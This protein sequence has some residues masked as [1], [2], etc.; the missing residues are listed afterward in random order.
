[1]GTPDDYISQTLKRIRYS[2]QKVC[3]ATA[4]IRLRHREQYNKRPEQLQYKRGDRVLLSPVVPDKDLQVCIKIQRTLSRHQEFVIYLLRT[5]PTRL[6]SPSVSTW[7]ASL[8]CWKRCCGVIR[9]HLNST[10]QKISCAPSTKR[11]RV[12]HASTT[13]SCSLKKEKFYFLPLRV[14]VNIS[15]NRLKTARLIK[16]QVWS[17]PTKKKSCILLVHSP[18]S[19]L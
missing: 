3:E 1:M 6:S 8:S 9:M 17:H 4:H 11:R 19:P 14:K 15:N 13:L 2:F 16:N 10:H 7:I 12:R 5:W 18:L